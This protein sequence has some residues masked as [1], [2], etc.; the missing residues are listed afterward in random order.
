[1]KNVLF[2]IILLCVAVCGYSQQHYSYN[3][4][5]FKYTGSDYFAFDHCETKNQTGN[6]II[7]RNNVCI[8]GK[9]YKIKKKIKDNVYRAKGGTIEYIY[10]RGEIASVHIRKFSTDIYY[11]LNQAAD[12]KL[13]TQNTQ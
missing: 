1:M 8:D 12:N 9:K 5:L 2:I 10:N 11:K 6:I 3:K 4:V 13:L 7:T